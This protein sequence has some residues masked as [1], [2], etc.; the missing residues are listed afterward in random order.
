[1]QLKRIKKY[2]IFLSVIS[3]L[4]VMTF[5]SS[6]ITALVPI[7]T[8]ENLEELE[9]PVSSGGSVF[10]EFGDSK[11]A[12]TR[13]ATEIVTSTYLEDGV[14]AFRNIGNGNLW[15]DLEQNIISQAAHIQQCYY[16]TPPTEIFERAALF[17]ITR[18]GTTSR[19]IIRLMM[20]NLLSFDYVGT[21][22]KTKRIPANDSDVS[23]VDTFYI[24]YSS[25]AGGYTIKPYEDARYVCAN[26]TQASGMAG[27]PDSFLIASS[28][29]SAGNCGKW[30]VHKYT[31]AARSAMSAGASPS[32][33]NGL[34][35]GDS[36]IISVYPWSTVVGVNKPTLEL[37]SSTASRALLM[38]VSSD[39]SFS[40][41]YYLEGVKAGKIQINY[42]FYNASG[43]SIYSATF[44]YFVTP[45]LPSSSV[46]IQNGAT[47]TYMDVEGPSTAEGAYIQQWG[48][49]NV[50]QKQWTITAV[51]NG[52]YTIKSNF[53]S[54][55]VGVDS[56]ST[57]LIKQYSGVTDY[58][59]W[60]FTE[61]DSGRYSLAN[62]ALGG[63]YVLAAQS[64][65]SGDG[66]DLRA[67]LYTDD[68]SLRD[69]WFLIALS[70]A[71]QL[72]PQQQTM[73]CWVASA[74][75]SSMIYMQSPIS[76][77]SAAV[78]VKLNAITF[79]P[80]STQISNANSGG[81][82]SETEA[83]VEYI[84]ASNNC[85]STWG[86]IYSEST[87]RNILDSE[88]PVVI[89]RGWYNTSG[90]RTGGHYVVIYD[91]Y[92]D[93]NNNTYMYEIFDP[94]SPNVGD[95]YSR[96]YQSICNGRN[97]AFNGDVT[98]T[99]IWEGVVVY[100]IGNYLNTVTWPGP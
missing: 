13:A 90:K 23:I 73:W 52:Y 64:D 74:R 50:T 99:G 16:A 56:S 12:G 37:S 51:G 41:Q 69:E 61:T 21:E 63:S 49:S 100:E 15:M 47:S 80:T 66:S 53:S 11:D 40:Y 14:Y 57:T 62:K 77:A 84:L 70:Y 65:T 29:S 3:V 91:Y 4:L 33:T 10:E 58:T 76:Q 8:G 92:W 97:P 28:Q 75:M 87:L 7:T 2:G 96:S 35:V 43:A 36:S 94:W 5:V 55:Y 27:A 59:K 85:Y 44:T 48:F 71:V 42:R 98:D 24:T 25:A 45:D 26:N 46:Y 89:L 17:K 60:F 31:G 95:A 39:L 54:K 88:N 30:E 72:E 19:Y 67:V 32:I 20:N 82:V 83:A 81:T 18:V 86:N 78:Y 93:L 34:T 68:T 38:D 1:M 9:S 79:N 22:V 6:P